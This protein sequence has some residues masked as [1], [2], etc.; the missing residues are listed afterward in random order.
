MMIIALLSKLYVQK[1][2]VQKLYVQDSYETKYLYLIKKREKNGLE[3]LK[4]LKAF[5]EYS[6]NMQDFIKNIE[7]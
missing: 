2:Y 6:N 1:L 3:N 5:I 7:K 4:D